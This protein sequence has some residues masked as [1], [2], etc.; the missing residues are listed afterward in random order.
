MSDK[1]PSDNKSPSSKN[2]PRASR[3]PKGYVGL[4]H[5]TIGSDLLAVRDALLS[6]SA[7]KSDAATSMLCRQVL[8]SESAERIEQVKAEQW[9]PIEWLL[10]MLEALD[11]KVGPN[12]L[13]RLGRVLFARSHQEQAKRHFRSACE[14]LSAFDTLYHNAN[15]GQQVGGWKVLSFDRAR[16]ELEKSTPHHCVME[17]GIVLEA[18]AAMGC[19]VVVSQRE[20]FRQGANVCVYVVAP[21]AL[22]DPSWGV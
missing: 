22:G 2:P 5:E 19:R 20:C 14:I 17:E 12:G 21:V 11:S 13:R 15:R 1:P 18:C 10:T 7:D 6:L 9:Y 4:H 8:G 16:A 3:R